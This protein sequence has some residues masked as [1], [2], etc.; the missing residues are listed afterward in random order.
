M[1]QLFAEWNEGYINIV[2]TREYQVI[3]FKYI[4]ENL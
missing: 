3:N 4:Q 1:T 2:F